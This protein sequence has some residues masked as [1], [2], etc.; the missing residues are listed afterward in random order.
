MEKRYWIHKPIKGD[1]FE[2]IYSSEDFWG[3]TLLWFFAR[4]IGIALIV[5]LFLLFSLFA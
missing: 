5:G 3:V 4:I 1:D 2:E